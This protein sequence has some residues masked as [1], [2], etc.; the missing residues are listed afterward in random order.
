[1]AS[2][3][4]AAPNAGGIE[5]DEDAQSI[6]GAAPLRDADAPGARGDGPG[7]GGPR[8]AGGGHDRALSLAIRA[9]ALLSLAM[10]KDERWRS[11]RR[12][13][14]A[15]S[16]AVVLTVILTMVG[17]NI[18]L[19]GVT[20]RLA[21]FTAMLWILLVGLRLHSIAQGTLARQASRVS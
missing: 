5:D 12:P 6:T 20:Q 2:C 17:S 15:V 9:L 14:L 10:G 1:M 16:F 21:N 18:G 3:V 11:F 8:G 19:F 13:A 7:M 4:Q